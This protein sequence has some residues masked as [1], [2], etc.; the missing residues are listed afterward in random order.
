MTMPAVCS[1]SGP[2]VTNPNRLQ[3]TSNR[4]RRIG[5]L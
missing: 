3:V 4:M 5:E 1:A 2:A